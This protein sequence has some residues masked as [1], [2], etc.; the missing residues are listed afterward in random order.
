MFD[1]YLETRKECVIVNFNYLH[2]PTDNR[3]R[4]VYILFNGKHPLNAFDTQMLAHISSKLISERGTQPFTLQ[5][6]ITKADCMPGDKLPETIAKLRKYIWEAAPLCLPPIVTSATMN[7]PFGIE[8]MRQNIAEA[9]TYVWVA[10]YCRMATAS[11]FALVVLYDYGQPGTG[12]TRLGY[13]RCF[14]PME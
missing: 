13:K 9:W 7:P 8:E 2:L 14:S 5:A 12:Q 4:R 1:K 3:L 11:F 10:D 6:V